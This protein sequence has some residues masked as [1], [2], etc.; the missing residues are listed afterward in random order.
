MENLVDK[1]SGRLVSLD[2]LRGFDMLFIMGLAPL[3][4]SVCSLFP[5]GESCWLAGTMDHAQWH[6]FNHHDTIFPL[7]LFIAGISFPFSYAKQQAN[8][9]SRGRI[10]LKIF[11]RAITLVLLGLV[12][13]GLFNLDFKDLRVASVLGRIGVAWMVAALLFINLCT[14]TRAVIA[15]LILVGYWLL[16]W[17]VP[18]TDAPAGAD[19]FSFEYNLA[20]Y[21]DQLL[22]PGAVYYGTFDPEGILS[23]L[24]AVVTAMLG[25]FTGEFVRL[26]ESSV[27][28]RRKALYMFLAA[29][30]FLAVGLLWNTVFPVNKKLWTSSFVCVVASYSL[31]LFSLFYYLT[32]VRKWQ[33]WTLFFRVVGLNSI[34]IY[35]AQVIIDFGGI[36][37]FFLGGLA[38]LCSPQW[39]AV[40]NGAGYMAVCWLFLYFLYKHKVFLKV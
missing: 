21:V 24:P 39:G 12:Y 7:F 40:I 32:D 26:P 27:S 13:N 1:K 5:G 17:L 14:R 8:G 2:A 10:Y 37:D 3:V 23:T 34:T 33:G 28:G 35:L 31:G 20:G 19:P 18:A 22:L 36:S 6:G 9:A 4:V 16:L 15:A 11:R 29:V 30:A 38:G 25:M